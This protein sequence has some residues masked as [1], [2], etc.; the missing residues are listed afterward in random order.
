MSL[1]SSGSMV[2]KRGPDELAAAGSGRNMSDSS[3]SFLSFFE[4]GY[5][6]SICDRS[7]LPVC[8]SSQ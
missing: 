1:E 8:V 3:S 5:A 6:D 2:G 4:S 7:C